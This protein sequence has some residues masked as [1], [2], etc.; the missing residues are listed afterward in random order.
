LGLL[1]RL[2]ASAPSRIVNTASDAHASAHLD[3]DDLQSAR[4]YAHRDL[5]ELLRHGGPGY[6]VYARSKLCNLLFTR[7]LAAR[8]SGSGITVNALHPGFVATR[9]AEGAGGLIEFGMRIA[10]RFARPPEKGAETLVHLASAPELTGTSG[11]YF[12][13]RVAVAASPAAGDDA[14]AERLWQESMRLSTQ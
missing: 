3:F 2:R 11:L 7:A 9:F 8:L 12:H 14:A 13:D 10:K 6:E 4:C 1:E 5:G